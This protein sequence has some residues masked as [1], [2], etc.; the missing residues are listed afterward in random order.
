MTPADA[1][2]RGA[3]PQP[4]PESARIISIDA[5]RG[6]AVLGI[7]IMNI[8]SFSMPIAAYGNPTAYGDLSGANLWVWIVSHVIAAQ[9]MITIFSML[10]GAGIVL[11]TERAEGTGQPALLHFRR[12]AWLIVFG[13]LHAHLLW[14]G[15]V[16]YAYGMCGIAAY[17]FRQQRPAVLLV[18]AVVF[19]TFAS[20]S[21]VSLG[22]S[23]E[24]ASPDAVAELETGWRPPPESIASELAAYRGGWLDQLP[25]RSAEALYLETSAFV[26][27]IGPDILGRVLLGMALYKLGV[28]SARR[29][30]RFYLWLVASGLL[31]GIPIVLY[32]VYSNFAAGWNA[33]YSVFTGSQFNNW[34]SI[35]VAQGW[36]GAVMLACQT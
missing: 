13:L 2:D 28:F 33:R 4:T 18:W 36:V 20:A 5:L 6:F 29:S 24:S 9:K 8:Q 34:A 1:E 32:G 3:V 11:M 25:V 30:R 35:L 12:M 26:T 27:L 14:Y 15:D 10:F 21:S 7:L 23:L 16:L 31:V 17:F 22:L 19:I